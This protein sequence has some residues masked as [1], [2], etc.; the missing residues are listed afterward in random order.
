MHWAKTDETYAGTWVEGKRH[1]QGEFHFA[2]RSVYCGNF[3]EDH[4]EG[5]GT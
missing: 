2:D 3:V 1:G 5:Q 4:I